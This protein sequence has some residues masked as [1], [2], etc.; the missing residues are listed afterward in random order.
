MNSL[1]RFPVGSA[2]A[3]CLLAVLSTGCNITIG[4]SLHGSGVAKTETRDVG[5]YSEIEVGSAI[6]LDVTV[7]EPTSLVVT[8]DDNV[9]PL[10]R[11]EVAG[12]RLKIYLDNSL[13]TNIGVQVRASTPELTSLVGSG[14]TKVNATGVTGEK[15]QIELH[16]ASTGELSSNAEV[17]DVTL[18]GASRGILAGSCKELIVECS[19]ASQM[20]AA[21]FTADTV[22]AELSGA[23]SAQLNAK[24]E[25]TAEASGASH[26]R[27]AGQPAKLT[28]QASGASTVSGQ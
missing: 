4:P 21:D 1:N 14:A 10:V 26:L 6:Q 22:T 24:E 11:T 13:S 2:F 19:G 18:S 9:L 17:M 25:L 15:F 12:D 8:A 7:G 20:N 16:G 23:S 3:C 27:Y 28:K 5:S